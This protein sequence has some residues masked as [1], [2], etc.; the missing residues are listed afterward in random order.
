MQACILHRNIII[1]VGKL[2]EMKNNISIYLDLD[3]VLADF[4]KHA[5]DTGKHLV[6]SKRDWATMDRNW[7]ASIPVIDGAYEFYQE[8]MR[9]GT[10]KFLTAIIMNPGCHS[11]KADWII[12]FTGRE[13]S[14]IEDLI[15]CPRPL[16]KLLAKP[17]AILIDDNLDNINAWQD[18]GGCGI[19]HQD[20]FAASLSTLKYSV[21]DLSILNNPL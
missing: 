11:G 12:R 8:V 7:W 15:L 16:K 4:Y 21:A 19:H 1:E 9:L 3:G 5:E 20:D 17:Q 2:T 6:N 18:A 10:V 13:E 14:I